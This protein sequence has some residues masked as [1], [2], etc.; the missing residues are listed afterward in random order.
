MGRPKKIALAFKI[1]PKYA[2]RL[3]DGG[4]IMNVSSKRRLFLSITLLGGMVAV[5]I[6]YWYSF[7][8]DREETDNA[9]VMADYA[10]ISPRIPGTIEK[11]FVENDQL[12]KQGDILLQLDK[13]DY[14]LQYEQALAI[15]ERLEAEVKAAEIN[16]ELTHFGTTS[17]HEA[18]SAAARQARDQRERSLSQLREL[19]EKKKAAIADLELAQKEHHRITSLYETGA[20]AKKEKDSVDRQLKLAQ[21]R[22]N[23]IQREIEAANAAVQAATKEIER[24][25]ALLKKASSELK[26]VQ[27]EEQRLLAL[28]AQLKEAKAR[29]LIASNNLKYCQITAPITGYV[30]Q[31]RC[32]V[33]DR[34]A[35]GQP[36][37][38]IVPLDEVYVEANFKETELRNIRINQP[39]KIR[40]DIYPGLELKG[41]VVG[42]RA[43]TGVAFSLLPPENATGNWIKV[44]QR[45]PVKIRFE[46]PLPKEYPLRV[47]CSLKVTVYT[48]DRSGK[49]LN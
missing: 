14:E 5:A 11:I 40:P 18:A 31:K 21:A 38:A 19:D 6:F 8:K 13:K 25:E 42:I 43:G 37:M 9:Y 23:A 41:R 28:K 10:T 36:L 49:P 15:F 27:L 47:G 33:G 32:Q 44:V 34:V 3:Q 20:I 48:K 45:V 1:R 22:L 35:P 4:K 7:L 24:Q 39:V 12:V 26:K 30:A 16:T 29:L 46:E 17:G 2:Q